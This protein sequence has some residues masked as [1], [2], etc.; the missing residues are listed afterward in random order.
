MP[1]RRPETGDGVSVARRWKRGDD[2]VVPW[3]FDVPD[4]YLARYRYEA[5]KRQGGARERGRGATR[6]DSEG[7]LA[8]EADETVPRTTFRRLGGARCGP[9]EGLPVQA[10][11]R[12]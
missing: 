2:G 7:E 3:V 5:L 1:G 4:T 10:T 8:D 12:A 9:Q 11:A 6:P